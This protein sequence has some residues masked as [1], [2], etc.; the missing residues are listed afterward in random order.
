[1][2]FL[3][4]CLLLLGFVLLQGSENSGIKMTIEF[5]AGGNLSQRT[6][7]KQGDR[8][9]TEYRNSFGLKQ[10]ADTL[11]QPIY[12]PRLARIIRCDLGQ[13]YEL[14]LDTS[15]YTSAPY[16]PKPLTEE[17]IKAR[18]LETPTRLPES[19]TIRIETKTTD[20]GERKE[21]FRRIARHVITTRTQT[22]LQGSHLEPQESIT[23]GWYIDFN[24]QLSCDPKR[25]EG[26][27]GYTYSYLGSGN[28]KQPTEK[29]EFVAIGEP[30]T[31]FAL[32][33]LMTSK[34][35]Y[36][37]P[38]GTKKESDLKNET[39]VTLFEEGPLAPTL[40]EIPAGFKHVD[41]IERNPPAS[42]LVNKP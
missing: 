6:T 34:N 19:P 30:E 36:T 8:E 26:R 29:P 25:P 18:R 20:T 14:N 32:H 21:I 23:D 2:H 11:I 5:G 40:F 27:H 16:P 1:M 13:S 9:R 17:E 3:S 15:E 12:G 24:Q 37:L 42:A 31:G 38:D 33:S 35:T 7:Y 10:S 22:L 28:G 41:R 39:R 4:T